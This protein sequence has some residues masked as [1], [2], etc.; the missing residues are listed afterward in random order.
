MSLPIGRTMLLGAI[1]L[2][3]ISSPGVVPSQTVRGDDERDVSAVPAPP[4]TPA[5][6][7]LPT[8]G[9]RQFWSDRFVWH[10]W[11]IQRHAF[12]GRFRLL[13]EEDRRRASGSFVACR[14]VFEQLRSQL[15]QPPIEG[16]VVLVLHGLGRSRKSMSGWVEYARRNSQLQVLNISYASTRRTIQEH[17]AD[18]EAI[19]ESLP[20]A[21][22]FHFV[23]HSMGNL[24][25]RCY[26]QQHRESEPDRNERLGR[27]V[28]FAPPNQGATLAKR[29]K[30][31]SLFQLVWGRSGRQ[32]AAWEELEPNLAV[33]ECEFGILAG[34]KGDER[35]YNPMI[36]G[37]DDFVVAVEETKLGGARDFLV[38]PAPHAALMDDPRAKEAALRFLLHG[39]FLSEDQ[40]TPLLR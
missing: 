24:V 37:D 7:A 4:A 19:V 13:D 29:F 39:H 12:T 27:V 30:E 36:E 11:R 21:T 5:A 3:L 38:L 18:L 6:T 17:A 32:I 1:L 15:D 28:M 20:L 31:H 14:R 40:R 8:L 9:G 33:P 26:L 10:D 2:Q 25:I 23:G 16:E 22:R 34:G 35:G